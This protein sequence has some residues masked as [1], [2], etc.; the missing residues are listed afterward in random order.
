MRAQLALAEVSYCQ[1]ATSHFGC[2]RSVGPMSTM[3]GMQTPMLFVCV[4]V[5]L[6]IGCH[7]H[8][9]D[10]G[11]VEVPA[12]YAGMSNPF[13]GDVGAAAAGAALYQQHCVECHGLD[14][15]GDGHA[16]A[17]MHPPPSNFHHHTL[18]HHDDYVFWRISEGGSGDPVASD[19]P[20]WKTTLSPEQIWQIVSHLRSLRE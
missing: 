5:L 10:H 11:D 15:H 20:A 14:G 19:M 8:D 4:S 12:A 1:R 7:G 17:D 6:T 2:S 18:G 16:A 3:R 13:A 9:D